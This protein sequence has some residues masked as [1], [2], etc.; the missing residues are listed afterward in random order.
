MNF[1]DDLAAEAEAIAEEMTD[2]E[3]EAALEDVEAIEPPERLDVSDYSTAAGAAKATHKALSEWAEFYFDAG[4]AVLLYD[5]EETSRKRDMG[6]DVDAWTVAWEGGAYEWA[7]AL[8]GG[9]SLTSR[10][11]YG[12]GGDPEVFGFHENDDVSVEP[13]YS[14]DLQFFNRQ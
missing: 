4:D 11:G 1:D 10:E 5:P 7:F 9:T 13:Y 3:L 6:G 2:E 14:F 8:T 12:S